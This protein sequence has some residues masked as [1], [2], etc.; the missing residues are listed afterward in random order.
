M[1]LPSVCITHISV[2]RSQ[3]GLGRNDSIFSS[4][5]THTY[6]NIH[7]MQSLGDSDKLHASTCPQILFKSKSWEAVTGFIHFKY[8]IW[9]LR[10]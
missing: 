2:L 10:E 3:I 8:N 6:Q 7:H 5:D 1:T 9:Q 4:Y